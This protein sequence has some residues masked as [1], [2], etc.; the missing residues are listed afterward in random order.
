MSRG[1]AIPCEDLKGRSCHEDTHNSNHWTQN[2]TFTATQH[3][4][5]RWRSWED[6]SIAVFAR[7]V[8]LDRIFIVEHEQLAFHAQGRSGD[9]RF[10]GQYSSIGDQVTGCGVV[11]TVEDEVVLLKAAK[12]MFGSEMLPID[13]V[14]WVR[15]E[16]MQR[17]CGAIDLV[18]SF[19][20][21]CVENL[22]V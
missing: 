4:V 10:A 21:G 5:R 9:E 1:L 20:A 18:F 3:C 17:P 12:S 13:D 19:T 15:V 2:A 6:A 14:L 16:F 7:L 22:S 11:G 8:A